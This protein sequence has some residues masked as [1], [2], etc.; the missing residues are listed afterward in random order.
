MARVHASAFAAHPETEIVAFMDIREEQ[1]QE[2]AK[3]YKAAVYDDVEKMLSE[4]PIDILA[5]CTPT[6]FHHEY[7]IIGAQH[8]VNI[9]LEKPIALTTKEGEAVIKA[10]RDA[11]VLLT[12]GHVVRFFPDY[13][14]ARLDIIAGNIG[15][16]AMIRTTRAGGMPR[17]AGNWFSHYEISGGIIPDLMLHDLDYAL[18]CFGPAKR[19][20]AKAV[21]TDPKAVFEGDHAFVIVRFENGV[22]GH[23]EASWALPHGFYSSLEITGTG[24]IIQHDSRKSVPLTLNEK[25]DASDGRPNVFLPESPMHEGPY[26]TEIK[27]FISAL[28]G[29][30]ELLV[31]P[32]E[33]LESLRIAECAWES[34]KTGQPV[35]VSGG[36]E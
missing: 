2:A 13:A 33:A 28:K 8:G 27:H 17:G 34:L 18:W 10:C 7:A 35:E 12:I 36:A 9:F 15:T 19:V 16:P 4:K 14:G 29:E 11:D 26:A 32:E 24:G 20:Y 1:A 3:A 6:A 22:I 31:K 25:A 5:I 30:E 23:F 21:V